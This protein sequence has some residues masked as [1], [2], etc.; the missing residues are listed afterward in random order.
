[1]L[2]GRNFHFISLF[3]IPFKPRREEKKENEKMFKN[4]DSFQV[5]NLAAKK[6]K[7]FK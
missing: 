3:R 2:L 6:K 1:L 5:S 4:P 7:N